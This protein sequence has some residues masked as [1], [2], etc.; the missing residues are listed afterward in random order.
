MTCSWGRL[1]TV[2]VRRRGRAGVR[3]AAEGASDGRS[4]LVALAAWSI[5][6][7]TICGWL[8]IA[9]WDDVGTSTTLRAFARLESSARPRAEWPCLGR[10][11]APTMGSSATVPDPE[12]RAKPR[13]PVWLHRRRPFLPNAAS[14]G[15]TPSIGIA[16]LPGTRLNQSTVGSP[17]RPVPPGL[18][19]SLPPTPATPT[20][21]YASTPNQPPLP[22]GVWMDKPPRPEPGTHHP[23][24]S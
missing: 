24:N 9:Q 18:T 2:H 22:P 13:R 4:Q 1:V 12:V 15:T 21:G 10:R 17:T 7:A 8:S 16:A 20:A 6:S 19:S 11:P 23:M 5:R 14:A 3:A